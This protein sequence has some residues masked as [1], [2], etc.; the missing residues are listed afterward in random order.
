MSRVKSPEKRSAILAAAK[1]LFFKEG[2]AAVSLGKLSTVTGISKNT[3]Y[4]HFAN[5]E[6]IFAAMLNEHWQQLG[7]PQLPIN[8]KLPLAQQLEHF[9]QHL[10]QYLYLPETLALYRLL[11]AE[12]ERFPTLASSIVQ[13]H[14]PPNLARLTQLLND[15]LSLEGEEARRL[16]IIFLGALKEDAFWH[17][18]VGFR[19]QYTARELDQHIK[20]AV[21]HFMRLLPRDSLVK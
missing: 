17:V 12:A 3:L 16:A 10:L 9:A 4:G 15:A 18:L 1:T 14:T 13:D 7:T 19:P 6:A 11:I 2:Y 20:Q 5:K 21:A 8:D